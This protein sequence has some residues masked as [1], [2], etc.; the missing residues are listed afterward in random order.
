MSK[1]KVLEVLAELQDYVEDEWDKD[2]F[3]EDIKESSEA[4]SYAMNVIKA[5]K[6]VGTL[7]LNGQSYN[8]CNPESDVE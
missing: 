7:E 3:A 4:L 8:I 1:E 6:V 5:G 2:Q